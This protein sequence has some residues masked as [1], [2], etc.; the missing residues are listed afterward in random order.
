[1]RV[2]WAAA[3]ILKRKNEKKRKLKP[4]KIKIKVN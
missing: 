2:E 3:V 4:C 1:M